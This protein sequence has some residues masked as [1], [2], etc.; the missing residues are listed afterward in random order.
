MK[1]NL[2]N[3]KNKK[4]EVAHMT[5]GGT[6]LYIEST[7][8]DREI[9]QRKVSKQESDIE[10]ELQAEVKSPRAPK[11]F[12]LNARGGEYGT[13]KFKEKLKLKNFRAKIT[14]ILKAKKLRNEKAALDLAAQNEKILAEKNSK[15]IE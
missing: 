10:E 5:A 14:E 12:S 13:P 9:P 4:I 8:K 2:E 15:E 6:G 3:Q 1:V 7:K 11:S